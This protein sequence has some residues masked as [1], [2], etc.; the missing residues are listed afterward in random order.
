MKRCQQFIAMIHVYENS[1]S[2]LLLNKIFK[3]LFLVALDYWKKV[4]VPLYYIMIGFLGRIF[5]PLL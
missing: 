4:I 2:R 1:P 5:F 3:V